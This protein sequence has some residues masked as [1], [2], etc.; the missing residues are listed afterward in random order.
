MDPRT[1]V[2]TL[3]CADQPGIVAAVANLIADA[4]GN[5]ANADQHTDR[6]SSVFLQ[7]IEIDGGI[8]W[9]LFESR[10]AEVVAQFAMAVVPAPARRARAS[11][12]RVFERAVVR[13]RPVEPGRA[14]G[15]RRRR[16]RPD[17]RQGPGRA[18]R[19]PPRRAVR[20][21]GWGSRRRRAGGAG[22]GFRRDAVR[23]RSRP[24][25]ARSLHADPAGDPDGGVDGP[26]D[27]HPP[28][29]PPGVPGGPPVSP[30]P[31][32]AV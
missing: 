19:R 28:L 16:R 17:L 5:I 1:A 25:G 20:A 21:R 22:G 12:G 10:L 18:S 26:D 31:S 3:Q 14:R 13:S 30:S 9:S 4:G 7:R 32:S 29:V 6:D 24:G 8:D 15:A 23:A 27:Q 11:R 2:L